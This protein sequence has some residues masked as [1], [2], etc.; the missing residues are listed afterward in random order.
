MFGIN[1]QKG[2]GGAM[3][4]EL[5]DFLFEEGKFFEELMKE[6]DEEELWEKYME[7]LKEEEECK[8]RARLR[9]QRKGK[10]K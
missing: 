8:K 5:R 4:K 2:R 9:K 10:M 6:I 3:E 1:K 7:D